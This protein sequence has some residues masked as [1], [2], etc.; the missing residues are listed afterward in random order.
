[1]ATKLTKDERTALKRLLAYM[2]MNGVV[3]VDMY[4]IKKFLDDETL[5][6]LMDK[7]VI[8]CLDNCYD[9]DRIKFA[10]VPKWGRRADVLTYLRHRNLMEIMRRYDGSKVFGDA[11]A[12]WIAK[13]VFNYHLYDRVDVNRYDMKRGLGAVYYHIDGGIWL[14]SYTEFCNGHK[15]CFRY[16]IVAQ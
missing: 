6:K 4:D 13:L 16:E 2:A 3:Y 1:M 12:W 5:N 9:P 11:F 8:V 7:G 15:R 14:V 10:V